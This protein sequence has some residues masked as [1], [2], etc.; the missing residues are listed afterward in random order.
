M[1]FVGKFSLTTV[2]F[3]LWFHSSLS[4]AGEPSHCLPLLPLSRPAQL[5][6][7]IIGPLLRTSLLWQA[8]SSRTRTHP[9]V[10][11]WTLPS[12]GLFSGCVQ[13]SVCVFFL[14]QCA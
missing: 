14:S 10:Q 6:G 1:S 9:K 4:W 3:S 11:R 8:R 7:I 12:T 5:F 2:S 13:G